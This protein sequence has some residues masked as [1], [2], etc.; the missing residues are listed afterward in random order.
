LVFD[1]IKTKPKKTF[2]FSYT[3][4]NVFSSAFFPAAN[5]ERNGFS[6]GLQPTDLAE[7]ATDLHTWFLRMKEVWEEITEI[8]AGQP[9][10]LGIDS[11]I[12]PMYAG[13]GSLVNLMK[14][15]HGGFSESV[16]TDSYTRISAF[17][18][19]EN[20]KPIGL[21]GLMFPCLEDFELSD[22]YE[23]G[24]FNIER[25]IF[26]SLHSGLG[27]D[28]YPIGIDEDP[29]RIRL[30]LNLLLAFAKK[31]HKPLSARFV[32]DGSS[33]IGEFSD[34]RNPYLRDVVIRPL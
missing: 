19:N 14:R 28:T 15:I 1:I 20:P 16:T 24:N 11:S 2:N 23:A 4:A 29:E 12:A 9:D 21:C 6:I 25:N 34:F 10:F 17:I 30:I 7:Y 33:R 26:L 5:F 13:K 8:F 22:A 32:S 27:I 31:Y 3:F 18:K